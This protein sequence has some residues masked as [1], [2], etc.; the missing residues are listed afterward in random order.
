MRKTVDV[1]TNMIITEQVS[2]ERKIRKAW[3]L[4]RRT[5]TVEEEERWIAY[6]DAAILERERKEEEAKLKEQ[7][8]KEEIKRWAALRE[9]NELRPQ[10]WRDW[11]ANVVHRQAVAVAQG[12][13]LAL[14]RVSQETIKTDPQVPYYDR[15]KS[16]PAPPLDGSD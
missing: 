4:A 1:I 9:A 7:R 6:R 12:D 5:E 13:A 10:A 2:K 3:E 11:D 14:Q 16:A 8:E 15:P